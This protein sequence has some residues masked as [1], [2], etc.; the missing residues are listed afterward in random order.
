MSDSEKC[1]HIVMNVNIYATRH[2]GIFIS[3][4][5]IRTLR[6]KEMK[7]YAGDGTSEPEPN[8]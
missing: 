3:I 1:F 8:P 7:R 6:L 4:A 5:Q 2:V